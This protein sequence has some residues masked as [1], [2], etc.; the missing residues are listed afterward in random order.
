[1]YMYEEMLKE[2]RTSRLRILPE[3][4]K[5][6]QPGILVANVDF[7]DFDLHKKDRRNPK[8]QHKPICLWIVLIIQ[9]LHLIEI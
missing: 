2:A 4:Q 9:M 7:D 6:T 3:K 1:M 8:K 5:R